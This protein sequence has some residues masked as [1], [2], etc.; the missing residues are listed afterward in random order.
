MYED[1][2]ADAG[3]AL[4]APRAGL[5]GMLCVRAAAMAPAPPP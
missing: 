1:E 4:G 5:A 2:L 3:A